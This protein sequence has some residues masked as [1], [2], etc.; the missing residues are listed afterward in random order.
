MNDLS[1]D[2]MHRRG[3][4]FFREGGQTCL[5]RALNFFSGG[6]V[7]GPEGKQGVNRI[8]EGDGSPRGSRG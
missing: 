8:L 5:P 7:G 4:F 1:K 6:K 2:F 3:S